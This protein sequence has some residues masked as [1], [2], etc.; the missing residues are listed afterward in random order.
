M[1]ASIPW[2]LWLL[3][4][5]ILVWVILAIVYPPPDAHG[6]EQYPGQYAQVD[7]KM[8]QWFREQKSPKN[9]MVCC[10][11]AD[12]EQV[13]EDIRDGKYWV[14]SNKTELYAKYN[15]VSNMVDGW[16]QVPDEVVISEPNL[17]GQPVAWYYFEANMLKI[18]CF[19][20]GSKM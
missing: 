11:D 20:P 9:G 4:L 8:K 5:I 18:R 2:W 3:M 14:K 10:N 13:Q 19:A 15:Q 7:P 16:V 12:G 6:R 1:K 17:Y